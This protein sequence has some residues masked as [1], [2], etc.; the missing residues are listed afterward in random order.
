M[1][2]RICKTFEFESGHLLAK[3]PDKCRFPHGHSRRI[4]IVLAAEALDANDMVCDF[5]AIK[6][7]LADVVA[8]WD[9][10]LC[11]NT[12]DPQYAYLK[13]TY[14]ERI[15]AFAAEDPTTEV[16]ARHLFQIARDRLRS[17]ASGASAAYPV[18]PDVRVERV[19]VSETR[20][21]WA[22]YFE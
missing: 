14:G 19:R 22:E 5:K 6:T 8:A 11:V 18:R 4:E 3:H 16:L 10:A 7:A 12:A 21:S 20:S 17:A 13:N 15:V 1:P 9:H 2:F